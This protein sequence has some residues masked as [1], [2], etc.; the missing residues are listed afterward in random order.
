MN[1][2]FEAAALCLLIAFGIGVWA[3]CHGDPSVLEAWRQ[4]TVQKKQECVK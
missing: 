2:F 4:Q 3:V 1:D